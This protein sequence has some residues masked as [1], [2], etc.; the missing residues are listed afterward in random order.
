MKISIAEFMRTFKIG[1][2]VKI[3]NTLNKGET[4]NQL[5]EIFKIDTTSIITK[6]EDG[7]KV[8]LRKPTSKA[9]IFKEVVFNGL[10]NEEHFILKNYLFEDNNNL[11]IVRVLK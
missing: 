2:K 3:T 1:D 7:T 6:R 10:F 5:R 9:E 8:W 11:I 4:K